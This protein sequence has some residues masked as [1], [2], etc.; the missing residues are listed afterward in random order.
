MWSSWL[1][2]THDEILCM[3]SLLLPVICDWTYSQNG[4]VFPNIKTFQAVQTWKYYCTILTTSSVTGHRQPWTAMY[5]IIMVT[6]GPWTCYQTRCL[7]IITLHCKAPPNPYLH[8]TATPASITNMA[9]HSG[10]KFIAYVLTI[11][12]QIYS[13]LINMRC[14][15][16]YTSAY[17]KFVK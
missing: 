2:V 16:I 1:A 15:H 12:W 10:F 9:D 5:K 11:L 7:F 8:N 3:F 4:T 6:S 17:L 14:L 13:S